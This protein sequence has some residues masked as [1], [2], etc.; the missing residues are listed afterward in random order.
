MRAS[1]QSEGPDRDDAGVPRT[2]ALVRTLN[3]S[4]ASA[5]LAPRSVSDAVRVSHGPDYLYCTYSWKIWALFAVVTLY[6]GP[7]LTIYMYRHMTIQGLSFGHVASYIL[8][9]SLTDGNVIKV[10]ETTNKDV[11]CQ[12]AETIDARLRQGV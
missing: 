4:R 9:L 8:E 3:G 7:F 11:V 6:F 2:S 10:F 5:F 1:H 12:T